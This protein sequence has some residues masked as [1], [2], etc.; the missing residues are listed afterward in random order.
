MTETGRGCATWYPG[1][2][3][4]LLESAVARLRRM[5]E[6]DQEAVALVLLSA[7]EPG[8]MPG[9]DEPTRLAIREGLAQAD[10]GEF[11]SDDEIADLWA[12]HGL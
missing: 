11:V 3:T 1:P 5:P 6:E 7:F 4:K 9:L 10:R 8:P 2:M 12:K